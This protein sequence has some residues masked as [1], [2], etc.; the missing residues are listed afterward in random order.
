MEESKNE[1]DE[2]QAELVPEGKLALDFWRAVLDDD[3]AS[4]TLKANAANGLA[5]YDRQRKQALAGSIHRLSR[6]EL[7]QE[8]ARVRSL[9][10]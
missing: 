7:T 2:G 5:Q 1:I 4:D 3:K 8:I 9:L 10:A 6:S